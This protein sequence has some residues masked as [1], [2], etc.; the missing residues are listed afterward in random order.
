M[1]KG[2]ERGFDPHKQIRDFPIQRW[3]TFQAS[4]VK[5]IS[6]KVVD[7][8]QHSEHLGEFARLAGQ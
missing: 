6:R 2:A 5:T 4:A 8:R 1:T 3:I 7:A